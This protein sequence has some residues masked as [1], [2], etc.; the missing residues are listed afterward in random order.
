MTS[1]VLDHFERAYESWVFGAFLDLQACSAVD[2]IGQGFVELDRCMFQGDVLGLPVLG[3]MPVLSGL[4]VLGVMLVV[5]RHWWLYFSWCVVLR[6]LSLCWDFVFLKKKSIFPALLF[7]KTDVKK[8]DSPKNPFF[9][10][11]V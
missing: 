7:K 10:L 5:C 6:G 2:S 3:V 1:P 9:Y 11:T 8:R 4:L